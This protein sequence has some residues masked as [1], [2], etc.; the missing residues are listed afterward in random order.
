MTSLRPLVVLATG[1]F[2]LAAA[3]AALAAEA[4]EGQPLALSV[5]LHKTE[6]LVGEPLLLRLKLTNVSSEPAKCTCRNNESFAGLSFRFVISQADGKEVFAMTRHGSGAAALLPHLIPPMLPGEFRECEKMF[7]PALCVDST[8]KTFQALP[9]GRYSLT[10]TTIFASC[11][12]SQPVSFTVMEP[13]AGELAASQLISSRE[14]A[15]FIVG[16]SHTP[17]TQVQTLL[18]QHPDSVFAVYARSRVLLGSMKTYLATRHPHTLTPEEK[19]HIASLADASQDFVQK[20]PGFPLSDNIMLTRV[21]AMRLAGLLPDDRQSFVNA[22][23]AF[24]KTFPAGDAREAALSDLGK[25]KLKLGPDG[26]I[27]D[28]PPRP[29][30]AEEEKK[31]PQPQE[32]RHRRSGA[33]AQAPEV[34]QQTPPAI[35]GG[36]EHVCNH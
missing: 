29:A 27:V 7:V 19:Q 23:A 31:Y 8:D 28:D 10:A 2:L 18:S 4:V 1:V 16:F 32:N 11:S 14:A 21:R 30:A 3:S 12:P 15:G 26:G 17:P 25:K 24:F 20:H 36:L 35:L 33:D 13:P 34:A 5:S 22:M 6:V 9:P